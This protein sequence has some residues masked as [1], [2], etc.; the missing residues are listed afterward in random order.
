MLISPSFLVLPHICLSLLLEI[1][2]EVKVFRNL[3]QEMNQLIQQT[4]TG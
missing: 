3:L 1:P 4:F 2:Q